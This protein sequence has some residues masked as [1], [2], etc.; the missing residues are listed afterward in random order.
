MAPCCADSSLAEGRRRP[1]FA[2]PFQSGKAGRERRGEPGSYDVGVVIKPRSADVK[3]V[4][5]EELV[6]KGRE[7]VKGGR[8]VEAGELLFEYCDRLERGGRPIS[9]V[10]LANYALCLGHNGRLREGIGICRKALPRG[11]RRPEVS[12]CLARLYLL[13]AS[14]RLALE[15]CERAL[16]LSPHNEEL[17]RLRGELGFRRPP[18]IPF[19]PRESVLNVRLG[20]L[21][22]RNR[23]GT[24]P[25]EARQARSSS[26]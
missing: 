20:R 9:P 16:R 8:F 14:K 12:L 17:R 21:L 26:S 5:E 11:S 15:E 3:R 23:L 22:H 2:Q 19:L 25:K 18:P 13:A 24:V 10:I 1:F 4:A 7:A 6:R